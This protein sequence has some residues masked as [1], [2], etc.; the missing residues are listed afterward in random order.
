[1]PGSATK[2]L[3]TRDWLNVGKHIL[4]VSGATAFATLAQQVPMLLDTL[5]APVLIPLVTGLLTLLARWL[6][7]NR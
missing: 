6:Q 2:Q 1:M 3:N 5:G 4:I 7:D